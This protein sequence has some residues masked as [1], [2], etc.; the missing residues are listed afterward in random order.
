M[1]R[2]LKV[3]PAAGH[4]ARAAGH[5]APQPLGG[6]RGPPGRRLPD[7]CRVVIRGSLRAAARQ[8]RIVATAHAL[9]RARWAL[10]ATARLCVCQSAGNPPT[11]R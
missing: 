8:E 10:L 7:H 3:P 4:G 11:S 9:I 6:A 1:E 5:V 2:S